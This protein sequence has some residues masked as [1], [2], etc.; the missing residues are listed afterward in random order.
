MIVNYLWN[1]I[2][3]DYHVIL[4]IILHGPPAR[5]QLSEKFVEFLTNFEPKKKHKM[6][7]LSGF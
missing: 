2:L 6:W 1:E 5:Y 7:I 3:H 4:Y